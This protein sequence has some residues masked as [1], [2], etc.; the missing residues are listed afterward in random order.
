MV[1]DGVYE[2]ER[3]LGAFLRVAIVWSEL[4]IKGFYLGYTIV[5]LVFGTLV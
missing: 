4:H 3:S 1:L 2:L 5:S